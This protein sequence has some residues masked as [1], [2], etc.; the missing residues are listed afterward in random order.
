M[1]RIL[2]L[3][4]SFFPILNTF[5]QEPSPPTQEWCEWAL[6]Q[7]PD[8][9]SLSEVDSTAFSSDFYCL[10]KEIDRLDE[11]F[12]ETY[13]CKPP[14]AGCTNYWYSDMESDMENSRLDGG[15][16]KVYFDFS[17]KSP[18]EGEVLVTIDHPDYLNYDGTRVSKYRMSV[19]YENGAW[20]IHGWNGKWVD[21]AFAFLEYQNIESGNVTID[22]RAQAIINQYIENI[23]MP[24]WYRNLRDSL[25]QE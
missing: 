4:I 21:I 16:A 25:T 5:G 7:L 6:G 12:F 13:E 23:E 8:Q 2:L 24:D 19:K 9:K 20:R 15:R 10:L 11:W 14:G 22:N 18:R 3:V 17:P 1:K